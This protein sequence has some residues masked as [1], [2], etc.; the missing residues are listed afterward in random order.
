MGICNDASETRLTQCT[1]GLQVSLAERMREKSRSGSRNIEHLLMEIHFHCKCIVVNGRD[2]GKRLR[3]D[4]MSLFIDVPSIAQKEV[5]VG[6][7]F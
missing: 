4:V 6:D 5:R 2:R 1:E 3:G 7:S